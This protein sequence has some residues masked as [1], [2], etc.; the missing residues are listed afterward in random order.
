MGQPPAEPV[1]F[2]CAEQG[3]T[4]KVIYQRQ[5]LPGVAYDRMTGVGGPLRVYLECPVGHIHPYQLDR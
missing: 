3:C 4:H 2:D 1:T 5:A